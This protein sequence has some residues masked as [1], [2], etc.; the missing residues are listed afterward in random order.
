MNLKPTVVGAL[1]LP[2][3]SLWVKSRGTIGLTMLAPFLIAAVFSHPYSDEGTALDVVFDVAGWALF[4]AGALFRVWATIYIGGRKGAALATEGPYSVCR[5][6]LYFGTF[7]MLCSFAVILQS[8]TF[9]V[10]AAI[11]SWWY[12]NMNISSEEFRLARRFGTAFTDEYM[13]QVPRFWPS[14]RSYRSPGT[15]EVDVAALAREFRSAI[16]WA[17]LPVLGELLAYARTSMVIPNFFH[18]P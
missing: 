18:F 3:R 17:W 6:P 1:P 11:T 10:G 13:S 2:R 15:V 4:L 12:L 8:A 16:Y 7:L 9:A 5:N 14:F